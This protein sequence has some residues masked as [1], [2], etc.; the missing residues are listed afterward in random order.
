MNVLP[1]GD[2]ALLLDCETLAEAQV[3]HRAL[4]DVDPALDPVLGA[5]TVLLRGDLAELHAVIARTTPG[6]PDDAPV[7]EIVVPVVYDGDDLDEVGRLTGL[8]ADGVVAAHTSRAW[9]VAF[10]GF[11]PGF[12]Y[13][14]GGDPRLQVERRGTPRPTVPAGSVGL[15][16]EF[17]GIY[18]RASPGGWQLIG[19]TDPRWFD[20]ALFDV[21]RT[22]PALLTP[23]TQVRF[24]VAG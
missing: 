2:R 17:S 16:G 11:T 12:A 18:P 6:A 7:A 19:R 20:T 23:G 5:R 21:D 10:A 1:C 4:R 14:S 13:L 15:A 9:T 22:P 8:G 24:E 3:W